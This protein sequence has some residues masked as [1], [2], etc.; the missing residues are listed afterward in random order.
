MNYV[1]HKISGQGVQ[2]LQSNIKAVLEIPEPTNVK[3]L[4][5]FF[6]AA[7]YYH[8]F[9]PHYSDL[10]IPMRIL[11][12]S[13]SEWNFNDKCKI[14]FDNIKQALTNSPVLAHFDTFA[15]TIVTC[16]ASAEALG[17]VLSQMQGGE[18]RPIAYASRAL[19]PAEKK[20]SVSEREAL[21][22]IWSCEHWHYYR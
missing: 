16:D 12:K 2:P 19:S 20:Y 7:N 11:L 8:K 5:R 21:A 18:D 13:D 4:Q 1:G 3:E 17:A 6:G 15:S 14:A 9:I 22:C 10:T